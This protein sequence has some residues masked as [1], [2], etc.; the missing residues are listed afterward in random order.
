[1][2]HGVSALAKRPPVELQLHRQALER[3]GQARLGR[4]QRLPHAH[5]QAALEL[6][7]SGT[8]LDHPPA[9]IRPTET[10]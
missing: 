3:P 4:R 7:R 10:G 1:M 2:V 9:G 6:S 8:E 5:A